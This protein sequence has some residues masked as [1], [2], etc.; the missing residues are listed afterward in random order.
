MTEIL[1]TTT[2]NNGISNILEGDAASWDTL[3]FGAYCW[4]DNVQAQ[5][6]DL[7]SLV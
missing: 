6:S 5:C 4:C 7:Q 3:E 1:K 2:Y